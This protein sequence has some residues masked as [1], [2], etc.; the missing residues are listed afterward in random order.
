[1]IGV[2][3]SSPAYLAKLFEAA[4]QAL[5]AQET[6]ELLRKAYQAA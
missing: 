6:L 3:F 5:K 1:M 2:R 4:L